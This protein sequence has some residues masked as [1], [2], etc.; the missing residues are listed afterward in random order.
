MRL[1]KGD[2]VGAPENALAAVC[3]MLVIW[4]S[5]SPDIESVLASLIFLSWA[6][7]ISSFALGSGIA[8]LKFMQ[9]YC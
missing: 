6:F 9:T 7:H 5:C 1:R 4:K 3:V 2:E 8:D